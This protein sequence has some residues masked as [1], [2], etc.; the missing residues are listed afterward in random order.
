M[1]RNKN[2]VP[3]LVS[4]V[5]API[6]WGISFVFVKDVT[7]VIGTNLLLTIRFLSAALLLSAVYHKKLKLIN[8][9]YIF[10]GAIIGALLYTAYAFQTYGIKYTTPGKN[11]FITGTYVVFVP[12]IYW[13]VSRKRPTPFNLLAAALS[14]IGIGAVSL[15]S[16]FGSVN[17]GDVLTLVCGIFFAIHIVFVN[18]FTMEKDPF[19]LTIMQFL[20][21]GIFSGIACIFTGEGFYAVP[22][23]AD[24][25]TIIY[26]A[27]MCTAVAMLMQT[28]GQKYTPPAL[29]SVILC[30]E[31]AFGFLFSVIMGREALSAK[32]VLGFILVFAATLICE[33][34]PGKKEQ[35]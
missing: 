7:N 9:G 19:V 13:I 2:R 24:I 30:M 33:A 3:A 35:K 23:T 8:A 14:I 5:C 1:E 15:D 32:L 34:K 11:A 27:V 4:L 21:A 25:L 26:L 18:R 29:A 17:L 22:G 20:S 28:Y 10:N 12:F 31:S 6:I 16:G